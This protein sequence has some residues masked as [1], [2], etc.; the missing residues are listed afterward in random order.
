I[1]IS[2][3]ACCINHSEWWRNR[4]TCVGIT[5]EVLPRR[6]KS[7]NPLCLKFIIISSSLFPQKEHYHYCSVQRNK[8]RYVFAN[9]EGKYGGGKEEE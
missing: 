7:R 4:L 8:F 9:C 6:N 1:D 2:K 5:P 3:T